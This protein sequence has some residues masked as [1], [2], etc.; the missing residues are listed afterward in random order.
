M[1]TQL[2]LINISYHVS[3]FMRRKDAHV[4]QTHRCAQDVSC[5]EMSTEYNFCVIDELRKR[6]MKPAH[7]IMSVKR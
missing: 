5:A 4:M 2:Q 7:G 1:T 6:T 3:C